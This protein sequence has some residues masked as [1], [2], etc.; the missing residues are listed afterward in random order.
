MKTIEK[1]NKPVGEIMMFIHS[2]GAKFDFKTQTMVGGKIY[3]QQKVKN[4]IVDKASIFMAKRML[5]GTS[6]GKGI[7]YLAVGVGYG[8]GT[9]QSPEP[10]D[11]S[12]TTLRNELARTMVDS[13][14]YLDASGNPTQTETNVVQYTFTFG[15]SEANG[16]LCEMGLFGGD[17]TS[18][19]DSG[20]MFNYKV[21]PV[22]NK[23]SDVEL[24]IAW[25]ITF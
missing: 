4:L 1:V 2:P 23:S 11:A 12:Y 19:K 15:T 7:E 16:G 20:Y 22:W 13:Y 5:P 18:T 9:P 25:K 10:E 3:K 6:W 8:S 17:A 24:T 21:F 14:T